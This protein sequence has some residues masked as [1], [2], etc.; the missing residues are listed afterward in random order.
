MP[1]TG[2]INMNE[3]IFLSSRI[4]QIGKKKKQAKCKN[5]SLLLK[6]LRNTT[7]KCVTSAKN[8]CSQHKSTSK[9]VTRETFLKLPFIECLL[10][11]S[12]GL[13]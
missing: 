3:V 4:S 10:P 2:Y 9:T 7:Y 12:H 1:G 6:Y 8:M 11:G 5:V 13:I